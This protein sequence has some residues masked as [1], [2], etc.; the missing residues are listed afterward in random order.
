MTHE[1]SRKLFPHFFFLKYLSRRTKIEF[2]HAP[3]VSENG[4]DLSEGGSFWI[5][6]F[7]FPREKR[8]V[9]A[10]VLQPETLTTRRDP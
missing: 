10:V 3:I 1:L 5:L 9:T 7:P 6:S 8:R 2:P 4:I